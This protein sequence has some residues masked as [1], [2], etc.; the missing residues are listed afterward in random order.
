MEPIATPPTQ[1]MY[2]EV[3]RPPI[4]LLAF[5]L[6]LTE[7]IALSLWAAF[8]NRVGAIAFICALL[9]VIVAASSMTMEIEV[10]SD[11]LRVGRAHIERRYLGKI[12]A[13]DTKEMARVRGR[14]ADPAAFLALRFWQP[15][16]VQIYLLDDRDPAP[17]WL[18]TSKKPAELMQALEKN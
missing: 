2:A 14:D 18:V 11:W 7:S 1:R 16:G 8:D 10:T 3:V 5:L 13:L 4:W 15:L 6:F 17:Y 9:I 12:R